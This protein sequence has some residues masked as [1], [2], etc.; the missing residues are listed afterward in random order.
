MILLASMDAHAVD[1]KALAVKILKQTGFKGGLIVHVNCGDGIGTAELSQGGKYLVHG[2]GSDRVQ[3]ESIRKKL[4]VRNLSERVSVDYCKFKDLPY[5]EGLVNLLVV[6]DLDKLMKKGLTIQEVERVL[7]PGGTALIGASGSENST[8][9]KAQ[10]KSMVA[11]REKDIFTLS[12]MEN[13]SF[14][15]FQ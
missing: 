3:V 4:H 8:A 15:I 14:G 11:K 1:Q 13:R 6:S 12:V 2:L 10:V 7:A 9:I 5:T